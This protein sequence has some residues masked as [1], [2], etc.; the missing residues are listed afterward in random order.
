MKKLF[1]TLFICTIYIILLSSCSSNHSKDVYFIHA[2]AIARENDEISLYCVA[3]KLGKKDEE[4]YFV[5][6]SKGKNTKDAIEKM[7]RKYS[8]CYFA[9]N[10]IFILPE[11]MDISFLKDISHICENPFVPSTSR[12][13]LAKNEDLLLFAEKVKNED[14]LKKLLKKTEKNKVGFI[15]FLACCLSD[16]KSIKVEIIQEDDNGNLSASRHKTFHGTDFSKYSK[17]ENNK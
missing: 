11:D 9:T 12:V 3:Q 15:H 14:D 2:S 13:L 6:S 16:N 7:S 4:K 1:T 17:K 8:E 10:E 5:A